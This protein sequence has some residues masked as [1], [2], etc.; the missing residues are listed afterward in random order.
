MKVEA[1]DMQNA[2]SMKASASETKATAE[3]DLAVAEKDLDDAT[4][5]LASMESDCQSTARDHEVSLKTRAEELAAL[6]AAVK[7]IEEM[8]AGAVA[9][10]YSASFLQAGAVGSVIR[11]RADL[12][13]F[14]VVNIIRKLA[15]EQH[16]TALTQ[17]A[18][19]ISA[20]MRSAD[21]FVKVK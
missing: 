16:S 6:A 3:G 21:P 19:R 18:G 7:A 9:Q 15:R 5:V 17:L 1:K 8:T 10:T 14:E 13:N 2:K 4:K 20:A 12:T 11:S